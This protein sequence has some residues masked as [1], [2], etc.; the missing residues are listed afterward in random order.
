[1]LLL[2]YYTNFIIQIQDR[3]FLLGPCTEGKTY[4]KGFKFQ[5]HFFQVQILSQIS[6]LKGPQ[7]LK[8]N[9][10]VAYH[11][12]HTFI[13]LEIELETSIGVST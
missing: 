6:L 8:V 2:T 12:K 5:N 1:M 7:I 4:E 3:T 9:T 11:Y 13:L 10:Y